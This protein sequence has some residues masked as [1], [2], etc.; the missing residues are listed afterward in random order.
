MTAAK[1]A[2]ESCAKSMM[3][4][5]AVQCAD[6]LYVSCALC[7]PGCTAKQ[8]AE[9]LASWAS[10]SRAL[11][12]WLARFSTLRRPLDAAM[13]LSELLM[14]A[15]DMVAGVLTAKAAAQ[16]AQAAA[17]AAKHAQTSAEKVSKP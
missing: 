12:A 11:T 1:A 16:A 15:G 6:I 10:S 7:Q 13:P 3:G 4:L 8:V 9:R 5:V 14:A 2:G 17:E